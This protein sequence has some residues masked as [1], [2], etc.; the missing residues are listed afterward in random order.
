MGTEPITGIVADDYFRF[1]TFHGPVISQ[2]GKRG[3]VVVQSGDADGDR[4][5][6]EIL[7]LDLDNGTSRTI[8]QVGDGV[9][10]LAWSPDGSAI[11]WIAHQAAS[12]C[13]NVV[14]TATIFR[15]ED[16]SQVPAAVERLFEQRKLGASLFWLPDAEGFVVVVPKVQTSDTGIHVY[17]ASQYKQDGKGLSEPL[18]TEVWRVSR[19]GSRLRRLL[20]WDGPILSDALSSD[21]HA[22]A[23]TTPSTPDTAVFVQ[24]L[25][26]A[27]CE[28]G[29]VRRLLAGQGMVSSPTFAPDGRSL[30]CLAS[31]HN[32]EVDETVALWH[33]TRDNGRAEEIAPHLDRPAL[34]M[35]TS[36]LGSSADL[37]GPQYGQDG[38]SIYFLATDA[39]QSRLYHVLLATGEPVPV[40]PPERVSIDQF[41]LAASGRVMY[42]A[43]DSTHPD[44]L[45]V[46]DDR[47]ERQLTH[48]NAAVTDGMT[49]RPVER[50]S[51]EGADGWTI[52]G[53]LQLPQEGL[54][55]GPPF[56]LVLM[57]HG[58]PRGA[59]GWGF[60]YDIQTLAGR[61]L[62]VLF[63]NP[64]GSDTYGKEFANA[65]IGD[66]G[67]KDYQDLMAA[68]D[69]AV[70]RQIAD[71]ERLGVTGYSYGGFMSSWIIGHTNRFKAA[72]PG[73]CVSNLVS[74]HGTSDIG[75]YWGPKQHRA[76]VW[77]DMEHLWSMS[78][79]AYV[80]HV[81][82]PTLLYHAEG[83]DRCPIGQSEELYAALKARGQDVTFVRY[84]DES[85]VGLWRGGKPSLRVDVVRRLA[86]WF[87]DRLS[88]K[89]P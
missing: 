41:A 54:Y 5:T 65:V 29:E 88:E 11:A 75:W 79:L 20:S 87:S 85:H 45:F 24:D 50:F 47:G 10:A 86:D 81:Q 30:V 32:L 9:R 80:Q 19:D 49:L 38:K 36:D 78:P 66:W 57:I 40:S 21:G 4:F 83:D 62:A 31:R 23:F 27:D 17:T 28:T 44:E 59:F 82:T 63:V 70:E 12:D 37:T 26:C 42:S 52:D 73:G 33:I 16:A 55:A 35:G 51:F 13:I 64:R 22:Y 72:A 60:H 1:R 18:T 53:F 8:P 56:P 6:R 84:P 68:V 14:D 2:D 76:T 89:A 25:F 67:Q 71:P 34:A 3:A 46:W 48:L 43:S 69:A 74:F 7:V 58:G 15:E 77:E 39:G 61:G